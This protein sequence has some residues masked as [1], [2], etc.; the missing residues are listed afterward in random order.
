MLTAAISCTAQPQVTDAAPAMFPIVFESA[1][2]AHQYPE[3]MLQIRTSHPTIQDKKFRHFGDAYL[4][5]Q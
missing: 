1:V 4:K 3:S 2:I 5:V